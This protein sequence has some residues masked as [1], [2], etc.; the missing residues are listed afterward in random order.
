[1][2]ATATETREQRVRPEVPEVGNPR[3]ANVQALE[4]VQPKE[5]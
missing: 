3:A 5:L 1:M 4:E 2:T